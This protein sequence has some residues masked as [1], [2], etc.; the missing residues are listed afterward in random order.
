MKKIITMIVAAVC[1]FTACDIER[2]PNGALRTEA[3][4]ENPGDLLDATLNGVYA[5]MKGWSDVMHRCGEYAGD[6]IMIRGSSTD[7]FY[8]FISYS[9]TPN[10]YRLQ[11]FWDNSC[12][13]IAQTSNIIKM[14]RE[15]NTPEI[16][17]KLGE[18]YFM[19]G[20]MYF[21]L[22]RAYGRP[23]Y[24]NPES[25][26]GVPIVNGTPDDVFD[27]QP[28][29]ASVKGTYEQAVSDLK[30]A[31]DL[32]TINNGPAYASREAAWALLSRIYL[33]MSGTW[34]SPNAEYARLSVEY[35]DKVIYSGTYTLL[36]RNEFMKYNT[37]TPENN[38]ESIFV[39][40]RVASEF[41]GDDHYYGIGGMYGNI[42]GMGWGE[43]YASAKHIALLDETG[44][45]DW[46]NNKIVDARA[47]FIEPQYA[48]K[49]QPVF[50][51][52]KKVYNA[53]K[54][55]T[56]FNY[57]Q[58]NVTVN[59][60]TATCTEVIGEK[61]TAYTLTPVDTEQ[62]IWSI[63]YD[64]GE[65]YTGY[66]DQY[67]SLNRVYP[68]FY[69]VKCSRE[70]E[71]SHLHSPV[72]TRLAEMY[73]NKA[74]A[75]AK[76]GDY[77]TAREAL[78]IVRERSL[79]GKG[80]ATLTA[81]NAETLIEKERTLELAFQAE[82]SYDVYRNGRSLTRQYPGPHNAMEEVQPTD[83]RVVYFI[84]Q[85]AINSYSGTLT[86]NPISN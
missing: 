28:D 80:Y 75:A 12:E 73:L 2:L 3:V 29:R 41:S 33:Y 36:S 46:R 6:N 22:C 11:S 25:S 10:N 32:M 27:M 31:A 20:L 9:R 7:A 66:I 19:R 77:A 18:C 45:N 64:D 72:I 58:A 82:R 59:G 78:N 13:V 63:K 49:E 35:A 71:E 44:R 62:G 85:N 65:T 52:I 30:A 23:Y 43:M 47:A 48:E 55:Q 39:V 16:D 26:K 34:D 54:V 17:N 8:E 79:P 86:Q 5:Q 1:M 15:G 42:G 81:A 67:I 53:D 70:G 69:I 76:T 40:K 24:Q 83:F 61:S 56:N 21:Y 60:N 14:I 84:P 4:A 57:V 37:F 50:R 51:F 38:S 68:M 74:E